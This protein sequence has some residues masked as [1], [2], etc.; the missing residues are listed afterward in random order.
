MREKAK[1]RREGSGETFEEPSKPSRGKTN[2]QRQKEERRLARRGERR[3]A[4]LLRGDALARLLMKGTISKP[5]H[6]AGLHVRGLW[7]AAWPGAP[8]IDF[9]RERV[10]GGLPRRDAV[11]VAAL[12]AEGELRRLVLA[13]QIGAEAADVVFRVCGFD[14]LL[15]AI[16]IDMEE[17]EAVR[18]QGGHRRETAA[19][20]R[21]L[22]RAGLGGIHRHLAR[23]E[24]RGDVAA[25]VRAW[26]AEG[27]RPVEAR[28]GERDDLPLGG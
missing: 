8:A 28:L 7:L 23:R 5:M 20:V 27:A 17:D 2:A 22:I 11:N 14:M 16:A 9:T 15:T 25:G 19:L 6:E 18:K 24:G 21:Y 1:S 12:D 3:R 10:S 13:S 26:L 4:E